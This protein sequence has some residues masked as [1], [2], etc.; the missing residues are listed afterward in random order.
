M[1]ET[2]SDLLASL[3][4]QSWR[5]Q[6]LRPVRAPSMRLHW[7][8]GLLVGIVLLH[9][10]AVRLILSAVS[11]SDKN[12]AEEAVLVLNFVSAPAPLPQAEEPIRIT[13]H[14][15]AKTSVKR[16]RKTPI[17]I[18]SAPG[19][20]RES[21]AL[22]APPP[23]SEPGALSLYTAD[24]RV[25]VPDNMLE[26]IDKT[27]GDQRVFSYQVPHLDDAH[28]YFDRKQAVTYEPTRF[29]QY[30]KPDQDAL[31]E[32][33]TKLVEKTTKEI[34]IPMPGRPDSAIVCQISLLALGGGCGILTN[35]EDYVGPRDDPDTLS[36]EE[37]RQCHAWWQQIIGARTQ[38]IWR[39]TRSLYEA[40]CRKPLAHQ[41]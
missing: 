23:R 34:R 18:T 2:A 11:T 16:K 7:R 26:Q 31:T 35:G 10:F 36:K 15:D 13:G 4:T 29:E 24:G 8:L 5:P 17:P 22:P 32:L 28:K 33:L 6:S 19:E 14:A 12:A 41:P 25:R 39:K 20:P 37:D 40:Q 27:V 30:W 1:S 38:D 9:V 3:A 21:P